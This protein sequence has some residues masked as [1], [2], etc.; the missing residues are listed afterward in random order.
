MTKR[1]IGGILSANMPS[2]SATGASGIWSPSMAAGY[3]AGYK[4]PGTL[5]TVEYLTVGGGGGA[6]GGISSVNFGSGAASGVVRTG[7]SYFVPSLTYTITVGGGGAGG[8]STGV[9]GVSS[10]ISGTSIT[11]VT[12]TGG[13]GAANGFTGSSNA[14]YSGSATGSGAYGAGGGA[15]A[16][17]NASLS[18]GGAAASST[19]TG[20]TLYYGGGGAGG[21]A[22]TPGTNGG[23][24]AGDGV[25][26]TGSGAGGGGA[27]GPYG[28]G[29]SGVVLIR[30]LDTLSLATTTG[31]PTVTTYGGY[32]IYKFTSSGSIIF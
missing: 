1:Y 31:S 7:T 29:G 17:G 14:D 18:N 4:W 27:G 10:V 28:S 30:V 13:A 12:A 5:V 8:A 19:W 16:A 23:A 32:R 26:N 25:T 20:S 22:G 15:G 24:Y 9:T 2:I 11:T 21:S 6:T 3:R